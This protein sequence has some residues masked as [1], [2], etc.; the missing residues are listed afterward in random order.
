MPV[1]LAPTQIVVLGGSGDL[2]QKKLIPA[3]FHLFTKGL[4]PEHHRIIAVARRPYTLEAYRAIIRESIAAQAHD[5]DN[6]SIDRFCTCI[7]YHAGDLNEPNTYAELADEL[8]AYAREIKQCTNKLFYLAVPPR[9]FSTI[10]AELAASQA[11]AECTDTNG[12]SRI[13][14][15]KPFGSD[16]ASAK[17]LDEQLAKLYRE[18]QIYRIDHYLA[19]EAVQNILSFRFANALM[20]NT[21]S[22]AHIERVHIRLHERTTVADRGSFYDAVGALRDVGQN[23]LLQLLALIAMEEPQEFSSEGIRPERAR[24]LAAL[25]LPTTDTAPF[26][27]GQYAGFTEHEGVADDSTT[28]TYFALEARVA[29]KRWEGV[30]FYLEA[31]KALAEDRVEITVVFR[32]VTDGLFA[33]D[34]CA[35]CRNS[36][37]LTI[38]PTQTIAIR[39]N[40]KSPGLGYHLENRTL[41]LSCGEDSG[42]IRN[43]YEKVLYDCICGSQTVFTTSDEVRAAWHFIEAVQAAWQETPLEP[44]EQGSDGPEQPVIPSI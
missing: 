5:H 10:F 39:L 22:G 41:A 11:V 27:R 16:L 9:F 18:D 15:E 44:Y 21:W 23:H 6:E 2:A 17:A 4:L 29:S 32:D 37:T 19:K 14:V 12:W 42:E 33:T 3:L 31:G 36:V 35:S 38:Q 34:G 1:P 26:V 8:E 24:A 7:T 30:P 43:S 20:Q 28:E 25:T 13:L 40:A